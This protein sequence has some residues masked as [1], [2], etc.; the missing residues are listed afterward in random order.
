MDLVW[1]KVE[2]RTEYEHAPPAA[3]ALPG[4]G[5][6]AAAAVVLAAFLVFPLTR[7]VRRD[8]R[9]LQTSKRRSN[10][11]ERQAPARPGGGHQSGHSIEARRVH[12]ASPLVYF[13]E[14]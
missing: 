14:T 10:D 3:A 12:E 11:C 8:V 9:G 1:A 4:A 2:D 6:L 7:A 13:Y 5:E